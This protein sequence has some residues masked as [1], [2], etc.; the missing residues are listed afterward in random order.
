MK[1]EDSS[2]TEN[3]T[4]SQ[5]ITKAPE[6]LDAQWLRDLAKAC[7]ADDVGFVETG[8]EGL[9][10]ES[11]GFESLLPG[12]RSIVSLIV[13][14]NRDAIQSQWMGVANREASYANKVVD[15]AVSELGRKLAAL[16]VRNV[17]VH[18]A[19]P[20]DMQK[21]P[22]KI[23]AISHKTV[24][25]EAGLGK[26]GHHRLLIHP[27][28]GS[29]VLLSTLLLDRP[30]SEYGKPLSESPCDGCKLCVAACPTGAI[31][32]DGKFSFVNCATHN[33]RYRLGGFV[34]WVE[35]IARS[36]NHLS[37]RKRAT[38]SE[39]VSMWQSLAYGSNYTCLNCL[40]VCPVGAAEIRDRSDAGLGTSRKMLVQKLMSR[41]GPVFVLKGSDA[42][43]YAEKHFPEERVR[44]VSGGTRPVSARSFL[45][46]LP[47]VFQPGRAKALDAVY[48]FIFTGKDPCEGTVA[49]RNGTL[50]VSTGLTGT[51]NLTVKADEATWVG[52]LRGEKSLLLAILAGRIRLRGSLSLLKAFSRCFPG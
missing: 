4:P 18:A 44:R 30:V 24:A 43:E 31:S 35:N 29:S 19:F 10:A 48:H 8:R 47:L 46:A 11:A 49:I 41:I 15:D 14:L 17:P 1:T 13:K 39:T 51:P 7:G 28:L 20:M 52:F 6:I 2:S 26:M 3:A 40:S 38:D 37:Y 32:P 16:G 22:G 45:M 9:K 23:W 34:D 36:A 21:W 5:P 50:S 42:E 33:Y 25:Q 12:A 27:N